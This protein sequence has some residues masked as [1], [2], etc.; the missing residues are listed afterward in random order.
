M[1]KWVYIFIY[2]CM[3]ICIYLYGCIYIFTCIHIHLYNHV[4]IYI[5]TYIYIY[6]SY[7]Y[8]RIY[9]KICIMY[10]YVNTVTKM[11]AFV[12]SSFWAIC[13]PH[14]RWYTSTKTFKHTCNK[15]S[16]SSRKWARPCC[17][18]GQI[19]VQFVGDWFENYLYFVRRFCKKNLC[20]CSIYTYTHV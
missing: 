2:I 3:C 5:Y 20:N 18:S 7:L 1:N 10:M 16:H 6:I 14:T 9:K 8:L 19:Q 13:H 12:L 15:L 11:L 17:C 4:Y